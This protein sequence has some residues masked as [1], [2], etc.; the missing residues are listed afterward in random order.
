MEEIYKL[1]ERINKAI[2][3][4]VIAETNERIKVNRLMRVYTYI[5]KVYRENK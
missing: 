4:I 2:E 3:I 1:A 5:N